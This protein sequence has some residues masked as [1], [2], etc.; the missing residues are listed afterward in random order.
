MC[1]R[2]R[3]NRNLAGEFERL[4]H[5]LDTLHTSKQESD[6]TLESLKKQLAEETSTVESLQKKLA[7][8]ADLRETLSNR[9]LRIAELEQHLTAVSKAGTAH[10][11]DSGTKTKK[12]AN[13]KTK[14]LFNPPKEKDDLKKIYGIGPVMEK[15]LNS[16]GITSF[17]QI[18]NFGQEDNDRVAEALETFPDRIERDD[19][20]G[21]AKQCYQEKYSSKA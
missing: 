9:E 3:S 7:T 21:G 10:K 17:K 15:T 12:P 8:N 6:E 1:I 5:T 4:Q 14:T 11:V 2:D 20:V 13:A 18:A 16:L 19:W